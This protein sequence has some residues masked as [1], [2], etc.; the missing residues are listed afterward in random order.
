MFDAPHIIEG[1]APFFFIP[2]LLKAYRHGA[3]YA[4]PGETRL[5]STRKTDAP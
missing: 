5:K 3:R 2:A 1:F 4:A